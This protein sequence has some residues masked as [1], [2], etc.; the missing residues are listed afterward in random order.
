MTL[1][2]ARFA[3]LLSAVLLVGNGF[4]ARATMLLAPP[5]RKEKET[6]GATVS[7]TQEKRGASW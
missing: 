3:V 1:I 2:T 6:Y 5:L 7:S 4:E